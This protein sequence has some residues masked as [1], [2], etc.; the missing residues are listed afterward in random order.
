MIRLLPAIELLLRF[1]GLGNLA[2]RLPAFLREFFRF[3]EESP[4]PPAP[5][6]AL[7]IISL[8]LFPVFFVSP[9]ETLPI[10]AGASGSFAAVAPVLR[11]SALSPS[12]SAPGV[13]G[14]QLSRIALIR[15]PMIG[16]MAPVGGAFLALE[17]GVKKG[18]FLSLFFVVFLP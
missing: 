10:G 12:E 16:L 9:A 11:R 5:A 7:R 18:G 1:H 14:W 4:G 2:C 6:S 15:P 17:P 8:D 13:P 3:P